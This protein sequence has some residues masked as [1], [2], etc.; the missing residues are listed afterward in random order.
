M[1]S[2]TNTHCNGLEIA[3]DDGTAMGPRCDLNLDDVTAEENLILES[4]QESTPDESRK[5]ERAIIVHV[6]VSKEMSLEILAVF[7]MS[8]RKR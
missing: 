5:R 8:G 3:P 7:G 6:A 4:P 2:R 1:D